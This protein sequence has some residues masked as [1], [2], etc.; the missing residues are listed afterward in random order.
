MAIF[1][2]GH[3][4]IAGDPGVNFERVVLVPG[5]LPGHRTNL[6]L[7][8][9]QV[10]RRTNLVEVSNVCPRVFPVARFEC[11]PS[12]SV[13]ASK[14]N[15][16]GDG[17]DGPLPGCRRSRYSRREIAWSF[18]TT[19]PAPSKNSQFLAAASV[20][21]VLIISRMRV[22]SALLV[23]SFSWVLP[24]KKVTK[25]FP[26]AARAAAQI[27]TKR[28]L[29]HLELTCSPSPKRKLPLL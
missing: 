22:D 29:N 24:L 15:R 7:R 19:K 1:S 9:N 16:P 12:R 28:G 26:N 17:S 3:K 25:R 6:D 27:A 10:G 11:R 5:I 23:S 13:V 4:N 20:S 2:Q 21:P 18:S 14:A 8:L